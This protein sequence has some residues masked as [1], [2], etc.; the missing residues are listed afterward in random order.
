[1]LSSSSSL[2]MPPLSLPTSEGS[3]QWRQEEEREG[4]KETRW[5]AWIAGA[6]RIRE[7]QE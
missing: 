1:M 3:G 6:C 4:K 2:S 7:V 5:L